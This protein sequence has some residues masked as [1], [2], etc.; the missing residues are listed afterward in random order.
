MGSM[1]ELITDEDYDNLPADPEECFLKVEQICHR[2]LARLIN[3]DSAKSY[4]VLMQMKYM[5]IV[6]ATAEE[7]DIDGLYAHRRDGDF[8]ENFFQFQLEVQSIITRIRLRQRKQTQTNSVLLQP[9][10]K[11]KIKWHI[12]RIR[13]SVA[14]LDMPESRRK[15]LLSRLESFEADLE[16]QRLSFVAASAVLFTVAAVAAIGADGPTAAQNVGKA[17]HAIMALIGEDKETEDAATQRLAPP[18]RA[19]PAPDVGSP[20]TS[21]FG[22]QPRAAPPR[23][24]L[25]DDIP[26]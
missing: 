23:S 17:V 2:N 14:V 21:R 20:R 18:P 1:D 15:S 25:D 11:T 4:D 6:S 26:F 22:G 16:K 10:T 7:F 13:D 8:S 3:S 19:L 24:D 12:S 5:Q 9:N